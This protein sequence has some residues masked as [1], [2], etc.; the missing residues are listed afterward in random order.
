MASSEQ[1][2]EENKLRQELN[3]LHKETSNFI[4]ENNY[5]FEM[6]K[7]TK[8]SSKFILRAK[9]VTRSIFSL[10]LKSS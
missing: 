8:F 5:Y 9:R 4:E 6:H 2:I 10:F 1:R 3:K 7:Q